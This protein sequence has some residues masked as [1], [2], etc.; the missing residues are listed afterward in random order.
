MPRTM[1]T[2]CL[3]MALLAMVPA[4]AAAAPQLGIWDGSITQP[5]GAVETVVFALSEEGGELQLT[6]SESEGHLRFSDVRVEDNG[7]LAFSWRTG[8]ATL[9]CVLEPQ[10][11]TGY[12]GRC[13]DLRLAM[14]PRADE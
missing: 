8:G 12:A 3:T 2:G 14:H 10:E 4:A 5:D 9:E 13:G 1:L 7:D 11:G 6:M